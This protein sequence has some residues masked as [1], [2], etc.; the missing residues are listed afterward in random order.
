LYKTHGAGK[1]IKVTTKTSHSI[2][3]EDPRTP[4]IKDCA[5]DLC[6]RT[7]ERKKCRLAYDMSVRVEVLTFSVKD[8][9]TG[10][11]PLMYVAKQKKG[12]NT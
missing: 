2:H 11:K 7:H 10:K 12:E 5:L 1:R 4:K 3:L 9:L 6:V 8:F